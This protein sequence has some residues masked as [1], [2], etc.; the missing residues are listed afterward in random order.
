LNLNKSE[1]EFH[2]EIHKKNSKRL[3]DST[4][5]HKDSGELYNFFDVLIFNVYE[6]LKKGEKK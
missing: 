3:L 1:K 5:N 4:K 6:A 2:I